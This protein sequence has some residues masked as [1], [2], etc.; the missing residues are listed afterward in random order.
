MPRTWT[1]HSLRSDTD[2]TEPL[3]G[4]ISMYECLEVSQYHST[5]SDGA[6]AA[7]SP[8]SAEQWSRV[9]SSRMPMAGSGPSCS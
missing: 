7:S 6:G 9:E 5:P 3:V 2:V 4:L 8:A 1:R